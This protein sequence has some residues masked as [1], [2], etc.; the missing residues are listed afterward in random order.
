LH[1]KI[2]TTPP[3]GERVTVY[4]PHQRHELG[5]VET[6]ILLTKNVIRSR[7]LILEF[8]KR[9]LFSSYKKSFVGSLWVVFSPVIGIVTW[10]FFKHAGV[11][12]PGEVGVPYPAYVLIGSSMW[13]LFMGFYSSAAQTLNS[14]GSFILS[15]NY[16]HEIFLF[17]KTLIHLV[18]F[19]ITFAVNIV[20]LI[21]F[22]IPLSW[23]VIFF[24]L[25]I[26]PLFFLGASIGL[27]VS[28][29]SVVAIDANLIVTTLMGLLMLVTPV[30]YSDRIP[31]ELVQAIIQWNPLTYLVCSARDIIFYGTLYKPVGYFVCTGL[32]FLLF[33]ISWRFFYVSEHRIVERIM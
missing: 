23:G 5:I 26:L 1:A 33:L 12:E 13:G 14:G 7:G 31:N 2:P 27:F 22:G 10:V 11:L 25:V 3:A 32:S 6:W 30:I 16:P 19:A 28:V 29:F 18:N 8:F 9:D 17:E 24:P 20:V 15:V 4:R 21:L